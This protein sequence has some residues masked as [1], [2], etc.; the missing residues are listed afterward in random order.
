M[1]FAEWVVAGLDQLRLGQLPA[2]NDFYAT[3]ST[4]L[5]DDPRLA[6]YM[7][8]GDPAARAGLVQVFAAAVAANPEFEQRLRTAGAVAAQARGQA[9]TQTQMQVPVQNP[10][11]D[12]PSFFKTTNGM[13]VVIAAA[14]VVVGG[15]IGLAVGLSGGGS[16]DLAGMMKGTWA[17]QASGPGASDTGGTPLSFTVGDGTWTAGAASGTWK[18]NGGSVTLHAANDPTNDVRA[19]GLPSGAGPF[20]VTLGSVRD[21]ANLVSVHVKGTVS[22]HKLTVALPADNGT[23]DLT[24]TK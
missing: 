3:A 24:C 5:G 16:G 15:G 23:L 21:S 19:N 8:S 10:V 4:G 7:N 17:C 6:A 11:G 18:Q 12:T 20:D 9:Q 1:E 13:L 14:V 2:G 22:A